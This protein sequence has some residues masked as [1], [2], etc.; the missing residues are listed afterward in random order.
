MTQWPVPGSTPGNPGSIQ[1]SFP[2]AGADNT[3]YAN[4]TLETWD[5]TKIRF[6]CMNCHNFIQNNDFVWSLQMNAF[7]PAQ[8][9]LGARPSSPAVTALRSLLQEHIKQ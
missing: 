7:T 8:D 6:G 5:Q 2:G 4:T 9:A 3:A 1:F